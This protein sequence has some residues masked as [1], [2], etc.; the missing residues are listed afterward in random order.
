M[1]SLLE[2]KLIVVTGKGGAGKST[3]AAALGLLGARRGLRTIVVEVGEQD[4][5]A[6]LHGGTESQPN[7]EDSEAGARQVAGTEI[8]LEPN[9]WSLSLDPELDLIEWMRDLGGRMSARVLASSSSFQY[10]AEAAPGAKE[11]VSLVKLHELSAAG[12]GRYDLVV[13]DAPATGHALAMLASPRTLRAIVRSSPLAQRAADVQAML[14]DPRHTGYVAVARATDM[15]V[16]ETIE[17]EEGLNQCLDRDLDSVVLNAVLPRRF[18]PAEM[19]RVE[20]VVAPGAPSA[21][22]RAAQIV[23]ERGRM[24]QNQIA[25]LRRH[26]ESRRAAD[27]VTTVPFAFVTEI[28]LAALGRIA[29]R[30]ARGLRLD[31]ASSGHAGESRSSSSG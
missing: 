23:H 17:L 4:R 5:L 12:K 8:E 2:R 26:R 15:A 14:E 31:Q 20:R 28:G 3:I 9:L 21:A 16:S 25:R 19:E 11:L 22:V 10:L 18:T 30:L 7:R 6:R 27:S 1:T 29:A 24:Q 13:F